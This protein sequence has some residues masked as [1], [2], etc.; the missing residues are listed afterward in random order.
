VAAEHL[1][2]FLRDAEKRGVTVLL[3]GIRPDL[4]KILENIRL[5]SWLPADRLFPEGD[6]AFSATLRAVRHAADLANN[7]TV[8]NGFHPEEKADAAEPAYYLV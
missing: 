6:E 5:K 7:D 2:Q 8:D 1:E 3:A 4:L